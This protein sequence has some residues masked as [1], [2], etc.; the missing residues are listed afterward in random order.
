MPL[1]TFAPTVGPSV[2]SGSTLAPKVLMADFGDGYN[3]RFADGIN[4]NPENWQLRWGLLNQTQMTEVWSFLKARNGAEAFLW[5]APGSPTA[6][7]PPVP[8]PQKYICLNADRSTIDGLLW[9]IT[10]EFKQVFDH[11]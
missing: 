6:G 3:Q 9:T 1:L 4:S 7:V 2:G 11:G 5:A 8:I 10:A